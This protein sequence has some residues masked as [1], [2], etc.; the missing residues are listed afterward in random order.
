MNSFD[1]AVDLGWMEFNQGFD[2]IK[3]VNELFFPSQY[4]LD[5]GN[6]WSGMALDCLVEVIN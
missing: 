1:V 3:L 5:A 6:D 2:A 4:F